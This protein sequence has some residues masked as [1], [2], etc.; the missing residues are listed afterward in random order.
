MADIPSW[1]RVGAKIVYIGQGVWDWYG[2]Q[3]PVPG[4]VYAIRAV[5]TAEDSPGLVGVKLVEIVNRTVHFSGGRV[6]ERYYDLA[7][8]RP[9]VTEADD[10]ALFQRLVA[11][12]PVSE[13]LDRL[14]E[15]LN[16]DA[17]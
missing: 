14:A 3:Q 15:K 5:G 17:R 8:F 13:R 10:V 9:L 4:M 12:M 7:Q 16:E 1:A 11:D 6:G 2:L